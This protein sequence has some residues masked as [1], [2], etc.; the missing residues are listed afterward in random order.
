MTDNDRGT[1]TVLAATA[2]LALLLITA[3]VIQLAIAVTTRR[4]AESAADLAALAAAA[5]ALSGPEHAC[6]HARWI[7][8]RMRTNLASCRLEQW[9]ALVEVTAKPNGPLANFAA[10]HARSRAGPTDP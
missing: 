6:A 2:V 8:D 4:R 5:H 3:L 7:T 9:D 10:V 1:A